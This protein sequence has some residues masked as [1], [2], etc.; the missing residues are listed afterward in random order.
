MVDYSRKTYLLSL[1]FGKKG[2]A[3]KMNVSQYMITRYINKTSIPT[4]TK[5]RTI[6]RLYTHYSKFVHQYGTD[7]RMIHKETGAEITLGRRSK[8][9]PMDRLEKQLLR[10]DDW[11]R[12]T[13]DAYKKDFYL[14]FSPITTVRKKPS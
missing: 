5:K 3:E 10:V 4:T 14:K 12:T 2:I 7:V 13:K 11:I 6:S 8:M 1:A 9:V